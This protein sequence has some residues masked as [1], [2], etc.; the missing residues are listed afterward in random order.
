[1]SEATLTLS[2]HELYFLPPG[3]PATAP[4]LRVEVE[5]DGEKHWYLTR[6]EYAETWDD[7]DA[8][9]IFYR[10]D[11]VADSNIFVFPFSGS[12]AVTQDQIIEAIENY[13]HCFWHVSGNPFGI[14]L[15][16]NGSGRVVW[17]R[18]GKQISEEEFKWDCRNF[19]EDWKDLPQRE[20]EQIC[21]RL[22][23]DEDSSLNGAIRWNALPPEQKDFIAFG[24]EN[25][26]WEKLRHLLYCAQI[27]IVFQCRD[28]AFTDEISLCWRVDYR[29]EGGR[30]RTEAGDWGKRFQSALYKIVRPLFWFDEPG[31]V[32]TWRNCMSPNFALND[33]PL[34]SAPTHH[35]FLEA[36]LELREF[37]RPHLSDEA[38]EKLLSP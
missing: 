19:E 17:R 38:I 34:C 27:L 32:W 29:W 31:Y 4:A 37:L 8:F 13:G 33:I 22:L 30:T 28:F 12:V 24:C 3:T 6:V 11:C 7:F 23:A 25:G 20:F 1:M 2:E 16:D 10:K 15:F 18:E 36:Q 9:N 5:V 26:D 35:E 21:Q 14:T